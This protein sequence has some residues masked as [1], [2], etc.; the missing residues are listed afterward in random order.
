MFKKHITILAIAMIAL[1]SC[2]DKIS[3]S[4]NEGGPDKG[5]EEVVYP[6]EK[7]FY[8]VGGI[9]KTL[10][11]STQVLWERGDKISIFW[12]EAGG[13]RTSAEANPY[14]SSLEAKFSAKVSEQA[15]TFYAVHPHS[16]AASL[17]DKGVSVQIPAVQDGTFSSA[18]IAAAKADANDYLAFKHLASFVE[19]T[20]DKCGVLTFSCGQDITGKVTASFEEDGT[21]MSCTQTGSGDEITIEIPCSGTYYIALLP[22][23]QMDFISF[24]LTSGTATEYLISTM[25]KTMTR[26]KL[27]GLG[28]ITDRFSPDRKLGAVTEDFTIVDFD[29]GF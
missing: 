13:G 22:E 17:S 15:R 27:L 25:P 5:M 29:F 21:L 19:F 23:V 28:N 11:N 6:V 7:T 10:L 1:A 14:N 26:G 12:T 18:S 8:S 2:Q 20:I 9:S 4:D 24:T 3:V 16:E